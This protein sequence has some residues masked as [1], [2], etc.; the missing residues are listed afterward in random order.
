M[1]AVSCRRLD[2]GQGWPRRILRG[3][4]APAQ[5]APDH[6]PDALVDA[7]RHQLVLV[8]AADQRI[9][10]LVGDVARPAVRVGHG[11]RL[12]Q[13]PAREVGGA[14]VE[15]LAGPHE[16]VQGRQHLLDR[17]KASKACKL[18]QVD[19]VGAQAL[20]ARPRRRAPGVGARSRRSSGPSPVGRPSL[21][22]IR[23]WSRRPSSGPSPEDLLRG[24]VRIDVGGVEQVDP[25]LEAD[26]DQAPSLGGV[27]VAPGAEQRALA[28]EGAGAEAEGRRPA[29]PIFPVGG[30][31]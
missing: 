7:Q 15:H 29:G 12:H 9:V 14:D 10:G 28:A 27:G 20:R 1:S 13:L 8:V 21:V 2:L 30:I 24:A 3:Q 31:P 26:L 16:V 18:Q 5:G 6:G 25:G 17:V 11:Q 23:A 4:P 22:E 19:A